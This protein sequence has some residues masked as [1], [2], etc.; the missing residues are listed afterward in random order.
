MQDNHANDSQSAAVLDE[1]PQTTTPPVAA[2]S[3]SP[4]SRTAPKS[5][6]RANQPA[7]PTAAADAA[8]LLNQQIL[9]NTPTHILY[10]GLDLVISYANKASLDT[11]K[12]L[13]HLL[14]VKA[15]EVVGSSIDIFHKQPERQRRMLADPKN[16]PHRAT[17]KLGPEF[18]DLLVSPIYGAGGQY[19]GPMV[20][21]EVITKRVKLEEEAAR[22]T[23][24]MEN[25]PINAM[26][27]DRDLVIRY[28]NPAS[29]AKLKE[30]EHLLPCKADEVV[31]QCIDIFHK[32]PAHQRRLLADP[33]NLP[34]R[35]T[36]KLGTEHLDLMVS[37]ILDQKGEYVGAMVTWDVITKVTAMLDVVRAATEGDLSKEITVSGRDPLGQVGDNL[38]TFI[39]SLRDSLKQIAHSAS[40]LGASSEELSAISQQMASG[41]EETATQANMVSAASEEV[42]RNVSVVATGSEEMLS[43]IREIAKNA[44]EASRVA[45]NAVGVAD[46]TNATMAKLGESSVEIGKVIKVI[47]SIAQQ[48]NLLA[49]NATIEAA[50]AGEAG[51]GFAVV[52]N[53]V[54]EL[55][56]ETA[57]A[58]EEIGQK[59]ETIQADTRHAVEAITSISAIIAQINDIS[60]TIASAVEEQ[61]ATTNQIGRNVGEAAKGTSEIAR[62]I[63]HVATAAQS[64]T[65]GASDTEKAASALSQ[66]ASELQNLV[67]RFKL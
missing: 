66:I 31:G 18:L 3:R 36:I 39:A 7:P 14:P 25:M 10:A 26:Y 12:K 59:I 54:K 13:E 33:K 46:S 22:V 42:S 63:S 57:K 49:L 48:T 23:S 4:R 37:P 44:T 60:G 27:A 51:K 17:I 29:R 6:P 61:T 2:T 55:A 9:D 32:N 34:H 21:W 1:S 24:M 62:N 30:L 47:T 28:Q 43:S 38:R 53:E 50:R 64:T 5:T 41:A 56:K 45:R 52:A 58:T 8:L 16:L 15:S 11:L 35:A 67:G 20:T 40:T 19:I 65:Q